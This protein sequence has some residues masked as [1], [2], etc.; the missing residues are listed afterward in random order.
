MMKSV[1]GTLVCAG[2]LVAAGCGRSDMGR[3]AGRVTFQGRPVPDA[4]LNFVPPKGPWAAG[5]TDADGR[6]TLSTFAKG[7]G[8]LAGKCQVLITPYVEPPPPPSSVK[9]PPPRPVAPRPEEDT[10][11]DIPKAY[12]APSTSPLTADVQPGR[13]NSFEF[14]LE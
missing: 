7:D 12:R 5:K 10:R 6:F 8:S 11:P 13:S 4:V 3:V 9:E 2:L 1:L 14:T